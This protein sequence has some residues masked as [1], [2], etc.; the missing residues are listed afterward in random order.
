MAL[1]FDREEF[2]ARRRRAL[3]AMAARGLDALL[4]FKQ[5]SMYWL[6]RLRQLRLLLLPVPG[7]AR[8]WRD[9]ADHPRPGP[10]PGAAHLDPGRHPRLGRPR[11][12]RSG[13][14]AAGAAGRAGAGRQAARHR[15]R[16]PWPDRG[17]RP[18]ARCGAR[19]F[20][21]DHRRVRAGRPAARREIRGGAGLCPDRGAAGRR[22]TCGGGRRDPGRRRRGRH[23]RRHA[24]GD[25]QGRRRL[26]R[27]RLH[28]RLRP[29]RP[30]LSATS[31]GGGGS[32]RRTSS[33]SSSPASIATTMP[34]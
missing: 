4:I 28:H 19:R 5:E 8:R 6:S 24:R 21:R 1:H 14:G 23:P 30:A 7:A 3:E 18:P 34:A 13:Q 12:Q 15:V 17:E 22:G 20:R 33:R 10:A 29:R 26:S 27:Q 2:D 31:P 9:G 25:L 11:G 32:I 16:Q